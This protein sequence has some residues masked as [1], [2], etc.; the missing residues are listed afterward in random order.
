MEQFVRD[1]RIAQIYEGANGIQALDLVG[2]KLGKDG[3]RAIMAFFNEV[4]GYLKEQVRRRR[5]EAVSSRRSA[6]RSAICSRPRCGSCRTPWP[7]PTMPAP[8]PT[9]T[10][11]SSAWSRSATCGAGSPKPRIAKLPKANGS[12]PRMNAKLV[13]ARF[14]MERMLPETASASR[15]HPVGRG[16][17]HGIAGRRILIPVVAALQNASGL[18]SSAKVCT[19]G[20]IRRGRR[21]SVGV[22]RAIFHRLLRSLCQP[23][24]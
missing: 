4:Q 7:S 6:L 12:A 5:D 21:V 10:C 1:A 14:F 15:P 20:I 2:R 11:I 18:H 16:V 3:G 13:T 8:A 17:D 24:L 19:L 9:T 22:C 23:C